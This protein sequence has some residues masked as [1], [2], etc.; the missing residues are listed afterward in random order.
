MKDCDVVFYLIH[1]MYSGRNYVEM[2]KTAASNVASLSEDLGVKRIVYLSG[3]GRKEDR[4]SRHLR[5]RKEVDETLRSSKTPV[6]TLQAA[7][8]IGPGSASF[9]IMR[10]LVE[11]LPVMITPKWVR[12]KTQPISVEDTVEYLVGC[13]S[14]P[15]TTGETYDIGGPDITTYQEL[16]RIYAE[17]AGLVKRIVLPI[18]FLTPS[19]SSYWVNLVTPISASIARPLIAGLSQETICSENRIRTIL[20]R[21]LLSIRE[22]IHATIE[23]AGLA[24]RGALRLVDWTT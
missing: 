10:Y 23:K 14:K 7:M 3:L 16:M 20:P 2:D 5:S 24:K 6:T 19:L 15:E 22:S 12:T 8:I 9:E 21:K 1:S 13:L 4:L 18:P 11:R 17:E